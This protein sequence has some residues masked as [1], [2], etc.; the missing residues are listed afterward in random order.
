M[1]KN[2]IIIILFIIL[3]NNF[4]VTKLSREQCNKWGELNQLI[5]ENHEF[6]NK[7]DQLMLDSMFKKY[8]S[9]HPLDKNLEPIEGSDCQIIKK[10]FT[11]VLKRDKLLNKEH[12]HKNKNLKFRNYIIKYL[13]SICSDNKIQI[14]HES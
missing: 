8:C 14:V 13:D 7:E 2:Y 9:P 5:G 11:D 12:H 1:N 6:Q 4:V 3:N 10:I